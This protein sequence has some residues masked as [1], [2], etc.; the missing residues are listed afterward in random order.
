MVFGFDVVWGLRILSFLNWLF[1]VFVKNTGG[2]S[3]LYPMW[4]LVFLLS[5]RSHRLN[6]SRKATKR[7]AVAVSFI[8]CYRL[9]LTDWFNTPIKSPDFQVLV[10]KWRCYSRGF[11]WKFRAI[12]NCNSIDLICQLLNEN[13][14]AQR[15]LLF[16]TV[17]YAVI[18]LPIGRVCVPS[19]ERENWDNNCNMR[20]S[21]GVCKKLRFSHEPRPDVETGNQGLNLWRKLQAWNTNSIS[22]TK[23]TLTKETQ[24]INSHSSSEW[25]KFVL[26]NRAL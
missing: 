6:R 26:K 15:N 4:F 10:R 1:S 22:I 5:L 3:D 13:E 2:F 8:A 23:A 17:L 9:H 20:Q 12:A 11:R 7:K 21:Y 14:P 19:G 24:W 16:L 18:E 25:S